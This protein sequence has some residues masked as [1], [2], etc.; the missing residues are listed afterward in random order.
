MS[1]RQHARKQRPRWSQLNSLLSTAFAVEGKRVQGVQRWG[2]GVGVQCRWERQMVGGG[3]GC[4]FYRGEG[5]E[6]RGGVRERGMWKGREGEGGGCGVKERKGRRA[7]ER[8]REREK[9]REESK[10]VRESCGSHCQRRKIK[11]TNKERPHV[12]C[13]LSRTL[14]LSSESVLSS[15]TQTDHSG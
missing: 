13:P 1:L 3:V 14:S 10:A 11:E 7:R 15:S 6:E 9:K 4:T 5:C 2:T 12:N 8:E